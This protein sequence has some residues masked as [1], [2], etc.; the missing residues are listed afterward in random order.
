[1][2]ENRRRTPILALVVAAAL[3]G[4][5][6]E[7]TN[8][9]LCQQC[10]PN[11]GECMPTNVV[12]GNDRPSFCMTDPCEVALL[13]VQEVDS[14][15]KRCYPAQGNDV[16]AFYERGG[17][18]QMMGGHKGYGISL[19]VEMLS[20]ALSGADTAP[21]SDGRY[22]GAFFIAIDPGAT[23]PTDDFVAAAGAICDRAANVPPAPGS[24]GV[25]IPGQP[26]DR[27]RRQRLRDG[28]ELAESTWEAIQETARAVGATISA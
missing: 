25:L 4:C 14:R 26:E 12:S 3:L 11:N 13:C 2:H 16:D 9:N 5:G 17:M 19:A 6:S 18:L 7:S 21:S 24:A 27:T 1:M 10:G 22:N 23:R 28:I 15:V 8:G 20:I